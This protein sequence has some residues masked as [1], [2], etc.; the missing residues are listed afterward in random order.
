MKICPKCRSEFPNEARFCPDDGQRLLID[1]APVKD[2]DP[3]IGAV[4]DDRY[5]IISRLGQGG[6]GIVYRARHTIIGKNVAIKLLRMEYCHDQ[7]VVERFIREAKA[8]SRIGHPNIVDVTDFGQ[9]QDGQIYFVMEELVGDTLGQVIKDSS[10]GIEKNRTLDLSIQIAQ[11][12]AAAHEKGII[13]RDLKPENIFVV[14]PCTDAVIDDATGSQKDYIKLLDFG[15]AKFNNIKAPRITRLGSIF[16][17]PQYMSPE[18]ASGEDADHRGDIYA[19][20]CILYQMVSGKLP[21]IADTFMGTL[22]KQIHKKPAQFKTIRPDLDLPQDLEAVVMKMLNK[23]PS[24][25]YQSMRQVIRALNSC[26]QQN[27]SVSRAARYRGTEEVDPL[28]ERESRNG[29]KRFSNRLWIVIAFLFF[30]VIAVVALLLK[31]ENR[32][33]QADIGSSP[34]RDLKAV[35]REDSGLDQGRIKEKAQEEKD[36]VFEYRRFIIRSR[37]TGAHVFRGK[38]EIGKTPINIKIARKESQRYRL[39]LKGYAERWVEIKAL[40]KVQSEILVAL[41][42]QTFRHRRKRSLRDLRDP[43]KAKKAQ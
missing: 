25:R 9:L 28:V 18:Q 16:G 13:H 32:S 27:A 8:A 24:K 37:P 14:N 7:G 42:R 11:G 41:P 33:T 15:I 43:F 26:Y 3:Y 20:G 22:T 30:A 2:E 39:R 17:T 19:L 4:F 1:P 5:E 34:Q 10:N 29:K 6:M 40:E 31:A 12:L 36:R 38:V 35:E 21:F 23:D